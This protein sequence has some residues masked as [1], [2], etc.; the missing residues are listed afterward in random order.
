MLTRPPSALASWVASSLLTATSDEAPS[1]PVIALAFL[2]PVTPSPLEPP[3]IPVL[4]LFVIV[5]CHRR[6]TRLDS[7][8]HER[9]L[10]SLAS[11][12]AV[13]RALSRRMSSP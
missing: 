9:T 1:A 5:L 3:V 10:T 4:R 13:K 8:S 2:R 6:S 11:L 7:G 12:V